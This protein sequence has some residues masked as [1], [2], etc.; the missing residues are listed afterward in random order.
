MWHLED[1]RQGCH[2][3]TGVHSEEMGGRK[4]PGSH[5]C[6]AQLQDHQP[7]KRLYTLP[8]ALASVADHQAHHA[9]KAE[10]KTLLSFEQI[11]GNCTE[12]WR[13]SCQSAH[14]KVQ[15]RD[16]NREEEKSV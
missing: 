11:L 5:C 12:V 4:D 8:A 3:G 15:V 7:G 13:G 14:R 9:V 2:H 10:L 6:A 1:K 16:T